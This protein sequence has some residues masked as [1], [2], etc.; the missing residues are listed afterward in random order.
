MLQL[1]HNLQR[2]ATARAH[3]SQ[4]VLRGGRHFAKTL[5]TTSA[6]WQQRSVACGEE[7][8]AATAAA[9]DA[10]RAQGGA[11]S[12][13]HNGRLPV[14]LASVLHLVHCADHV[15]RRVH[16][17]TRRRINAILDRLFQFGAESG[18]LR[19]LQP[20]LPARL[21]SAAL[22][23]TAAVLPEEAHAQPGCRFARRRFSVRNALAAKLSPQYSGKLE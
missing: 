8:D 11:H 18:H 13:H 23:P 22:S 3:D 15:R 16:N 14:L 7:A 2:G 6:T 1:L 19:V 17:T 9:Q 5:R 21:Q 4:T 20:R 12:R 10:P